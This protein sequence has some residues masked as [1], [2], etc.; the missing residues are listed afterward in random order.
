MELPGIGYRLEYNPGTIVAIAGKTVV[1]G[2][3]QC[4]ADRVC[5]AYYMRDKVHEQ[6]GIPGGGWANIS[7]YSLPQ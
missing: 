7:M 4:N 6:L 2:V 5:V 1:H 3:G